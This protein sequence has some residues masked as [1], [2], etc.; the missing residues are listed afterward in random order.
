MYSS[1]EHCISIPPIKPG[2]EG[3][4]NALATQLGDFF[5]RRSAPSQTS[6]SSCKKGCIPNWALHS[7]PKVFLDLFFFY[8]LEHE[9]ASL[10][11]CLHLGEHIVL[12]SQRLNSICM[13]IVYVFPHKKV[14]FEKIYYSMKSLKNSKLFIKNMVHN[15]FWERNIFSKQNSF[16]WWFQNTAYWIQANIFNIWMYPLCTKKKERERSSQCSEK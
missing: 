13:G 9:H 10:I 2:Q 5:L 15:Y 12:V 4:V 7:L 11:N 8:I 3:V 1:L 16:I 14:V 6:R